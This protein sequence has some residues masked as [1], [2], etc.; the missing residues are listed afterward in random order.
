LITTISD[1]ENV[2]K[3]GLFLNLENDDIPEPV[4]VTAFSEDFSLQAKRLITSIRQYWPHQVII[5][6]DLGL[7]ESN[8]QL[9]KSLCNIIYR[10]FDFNKY[11]PVVSNLYSYRWKPIIIAEV[12]QEYKAI[13]YVDSSVIFKKNDLNH[14]YELMRCPSKMLIPEI[15]DRDLRE[16]FTPLENGWNIETWMRNI[17]ECRKSTYLFHGYS[18]HGIFSATNPGTYKFI[19][20]NFD[21]IKKPKAKMYEAG[22][23]Y[24]IQTAETIRNILK[25]YVAC[26]L[27][28]Q[29]MAPSNAKLQCNF[30]EN[31]RFGKYANCHRY[32]QSVVNLLAANAFLYDRHYY[33]SEIV[34]F[35][36]V[37]R[38][39][40]YFINSGSFILSCN[41][42]I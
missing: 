36:G 39:N 32:D 14:V 26:A 12:L 3:S 16:Q 22:I 17:A 38:A 33:V 11:P 29:C 20:T 5:I 40:N 10:K 21:E 41:N 13:W 1:D 15:A 25:W 37:V 18:G 8:I 6:Y 24:V 42:S 2:D 7:D 9:F 35:F 4:I 31:D 27:E 30:D 34:D 19:P 28:E 23:V